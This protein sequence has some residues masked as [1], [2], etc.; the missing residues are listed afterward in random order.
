MKP[1]AG[2]SQAIVSAHRWAGTAFENMRIK[3]GVH[4]QVSTLKHAGSSLICTKS[5]S[6][7]QSWFYV[8]LQANTKFQNQD[9]L[10]YTLFI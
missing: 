3:K 4:G 7:V 9:G 6:L 8:L 5:A 10:T 1:K 2:A